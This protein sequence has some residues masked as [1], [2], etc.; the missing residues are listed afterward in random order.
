MSSTLLDLEANYAWS[1]KRYESSPRKTKRKDLAKKQILIDMRRDEEDLPLRWFT[2]GDLVMMGEDADDWPTE[3][4]EPLALAA[5]Q[6]PPKKE[7]DKEAMEK[8][9][10]VVEWNRYTTLTLD[11][12][13]AMLQKMREKHGGK[14]PVM[15]VEFGGFSAL[16]GVEEDRGCLVIE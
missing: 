6:E 15:G 1:V 4:R 12:L 5:I 9:A 16:S 14:M 8:L 10:D 11:S 3:P 7:T 2:L 13:I